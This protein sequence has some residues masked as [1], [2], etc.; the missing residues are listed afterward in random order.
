[1]KVALV[2]GTGF[3]GKRVAVRLARRPELSGRLVAVVREPG[4]CGRL[5]EQGFTLVRGDLRDERSLEAAL[6]TCQAVVAT[7]GLKL[8]H[9]PALVRVLRRAGVG[10]GLFVSTA[11]IFQDLELSIKTTV[12][13]AEDLIRNSGVDYTILRPTMIY[14]TP[15]DVNIHKLIAFVARF[16]FFPV[17]GSGRHLQQPVHVDDV[18]DAVVAALVRPAAINRSYCLS[19]TEALPFDEMLATVG[20]A[21]DRP[22]RRLVIPLS[23]AMAAAHA[24]AWLPRQPF[25]VGQVRRNNQDKQMD[26]AEATRDLGFDPMSF[27]AGVARQVAEMRAAGLL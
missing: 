12:L 21:L 20:R 22:A 6:A 23:V 18:A 15:D 25:T 19:G 2:G 16:G 10:R 17:L 1:M 7:T 5:E 27:E 24:L 4:R 14:G 13:T 9:A 8:G 3:L 26:H 11:N